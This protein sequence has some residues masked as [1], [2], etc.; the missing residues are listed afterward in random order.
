MRIGS[1][2]GRWSSRPAVYL[3]TVGAAV[4]LGSIW[5]FPYLAGANGGS[6]FVFVFIL[7]CL[8]IATPLL[9]AEFVIGRR[10]R[11]SPPEAAGVV[12]ESFGRSRGWN[13]IGI[14]G[15]MATF[16][17]MSYYTVIAGW[18]MAYT[19]K[20]ASGELTGLTRLAVAGHF[21]EFL[22]SPLRV[23]AW[24]LAFVALVAGI[25][26]RGVNRG[27]E[28]ANKVR[29]PALLVLLMILVAYSLSTGDVARGLAF[30]FMPD[31]S[32]ISANVLLAAVGQAFYATGVGMAMMLAYGSYV[33]AGT[34]LT[35]SALIISASIILVSLLATVIIFPLVFRYGLDP[36]QG[37]DLVF[38]VLPT[39]FAEM[40]GGRVVGTLFFLLL[41]FAA[42]TPSIAGI[43]PI[44]AW[45]EQRFEL[46]RSQAACIAAASVWVLGI[47]S[48]LSFNTWAHWY[49][50]GG[51]AR[52]RDMSVF[53]VL[54]FISSNVL[55]P[56][57]ALLTCVL[58]GW[59]LPRD[60]CESELPEESAGAR[61]LVRFLVRYLCPLAIAVVLVAA[62]T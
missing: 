52:F 36:A 56:I 61:R 46:A 33:P 59:H 7:A 26:A 49:P 29:A 60:L 35:R 53:G 24:H 19:W 5:R 2:S 3:A 44:V 22:S 45:L 40:P 48:V 17:I 55:L 6:A 11:R 16:L 39:A 42:L 14:L 23:G 10:S 47:G 1:E 18:V 50:L 32:K 57:G 15:T 41:I 4:G 13:A 62:L 25:S 34:S 37:A 30:A 54:D 8:A 51:I 38:N 43:E 31:F 20:C 21:R 58:I 27:I 12:A 9:V 28:L